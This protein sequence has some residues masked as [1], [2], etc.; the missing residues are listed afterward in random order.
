MRDSQKSMRFRGIFAVVFIMLACIAEGGE[1]YF[2]KEPK[3]GSYF[4]KVGPE[5]IKLKHACSAYVPAYSHIYLS[6][7]KTASL[8]ITLSIR[9]VDSSQKIYISQVEYYDTQGKLTDTLTSGLFA[10]EPMATVSY[11]IDQHDMRGGVGANFIVRWA[12]E[13]PIYPPII[14]AI[15][16][17]NAGTQSYSFSSRGENVSCND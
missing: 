4:Y 3:S 1:S 6:K 15:M 17:G 9:N 5:L 8:G 12:V 16:A 2:S 14:E 7:N 10:L 11:V 13:K